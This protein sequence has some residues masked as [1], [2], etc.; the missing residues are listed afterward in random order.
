MRVL[1]STDESRGELGPM[2]F[3]VLMTGIGLP[4][5]QIGAWR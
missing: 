1:L 3:A 4:H 5:A 2:L